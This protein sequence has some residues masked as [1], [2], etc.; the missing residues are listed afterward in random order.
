MKQIDFVNDLN[1][2]ETYILNTEIVEITEQAFLDLTNT[3]YIDVPL[4]E[5]QEF[6][7]AIDPD[8]AF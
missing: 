2:E 8:W 3:G 7:A 1:D 4:T 5:N 6:L